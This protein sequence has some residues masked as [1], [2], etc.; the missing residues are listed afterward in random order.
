MSA[1]FLGELSLPI[2][3][4]R[5]GRQPLPNGHLVAN[6]TKRKDSGKQGELMIEYA[7]EPFFG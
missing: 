4:Q 1:T 5:V 2:P 7:F 3:R 6:P